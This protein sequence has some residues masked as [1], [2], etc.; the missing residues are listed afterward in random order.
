VLAQVATRRRW[1]AAA[2]FAGAVAV[3]A[4]SILRGIDPFDE[5]LAL[6]AAARVADG[7]LPYSD[8]TWAY[9]PGQPYLLAGLNELFGSSLLAWRIVRMVVNGAVT[10]VVYVILRRQVAP[11]PAL[12]GALV[13]AAAMAQPLSANPFAPALL[14]VL[15]ALAAATSTPPRPLAAAAF[16]ALAAAWRLD[17]GIYAGVACLVALALRRDRRAAAVYGGVA[18]A[19]SLLVYL[20]F[21]VATGPADMWE[22]LVATG[23]RDREHWTL[24]FPL[25]YDGG[26][27]LWPPGTLAHDLKDVLSFYVPLLLLVGV[28][29]AGLTAL[30]RWRERSPLWAPLLVLGG[31]FVLY[32]HSRTDA[33]HETPLLVV[34]GVLLPLVARGARVHIAAPALVV[35]ALLGAYVVANRANALFDPPPLDRLRLDVAD[36]VEAEPADAAALPRAVA[37]VRE[38][39]PPGEPIYVVTL[40]SD[41]VRIGN[42]LFYVLAQQPNVIDTDFDLQT[43]T[44]DQARIVDRLRDALPGAIVRWTDPD[45]ARREP[46][47]RGEPSDSRILDEYLARA[48]R[49]HARFGHYVVLEPDR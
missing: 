1:V 7:Q 29:L 6:Q 16:T 43:S 26:F 22:A 46:N 41:L 3:S 19:G 14:F 44:E 39:V 48:Y 40:R 20:P 37:A 12:A 13:T 11:A 5:G 15:L 30:L 4:F 2:I 21:I 8:F 28:G 23:L 33:F 49:E 24:P 45:S 34:L 27:S 47:K 18:V 10:V 35:L 9:G 25:E 31:C 36:G 38:L 32:L 17:F 42:P